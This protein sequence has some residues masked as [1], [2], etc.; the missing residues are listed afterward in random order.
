MGPEHFLIWYRPGF[1]GAEIGAG[2]LPRHP[3]VVLQHPLWDEAPDGT[4]HVYCQ[5]CVIVF[6]NFPLG[7]ASQWVKGVC[8]VW[9]GY[10]LIWDWVDWVFFYTSFDSQVHFDVTLVQSSDRWRQSIT[11]SLQMRPQSLA[12]TCQ[13]IGFLGHIA[14]GWFP[15]I[16]DYNFISLFVELDGVSGICAEDAVESSDRCGRHACGWSRGIPPWLLR[17]WFSITIQWYMVSH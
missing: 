12:G 5:D 14:T 3:S 8:F 16:L 11:D 17:G 13:C 1:Q 6:C 4:G 10:F 15:S 2:W 9:I 7:V